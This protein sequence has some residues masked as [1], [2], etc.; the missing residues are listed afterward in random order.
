M[1]TNTQKQDILTRITTYKYIGVGQAFL[2]F[3]RI[4]QKKTKLFRFAGHLG[5]SSK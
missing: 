5:L 3:C 2:T 1:K 4:S